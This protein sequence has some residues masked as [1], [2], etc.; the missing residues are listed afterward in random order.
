MD[1]LMPYE[2]FL[3]FR[4]LRSRNKRRLAR[5]TSIAAILG[6]CMGVAALIVAFAL[7]NG[8]RDEMREKIL[9]GTAHLSVVRADGRPIE[10]YAELENR[11]RQVEGVV[12]AS[13]TTY[14]GALARGSKGSGYAVIRGIENDAGQSVQLRQWLSEGSFGPL[15]EPSTSAVVGAELAARIGVSVGDTFFVLP[16][17]R[18]TSTQFE[19]LRVAGIFRSGLF[20]YDSTW[21]YVALDSASA[22]AGDNHAASVMSVQVSDADNVKQVAAAVAK[23][24]GNGYTTIDWQQANQP[25]FAALALERRM[26]LFIIGLIIA[27][28]T[29][30]ITTM[31]ILVVVERRRDI[32]ILSALGATRTGVMLLFIIEG[33]VVGGMGAGAGVLL[34]LAACFIGNHYKLV[35][36]PADVY[37]ISNVPLIARPGEMFLA[38]LIAFALSVLA[39][40]Y[41]ARAASRMRPVEALRDS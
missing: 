31:L 21:I 33:A 6:I 34:G 41:P 15:F 11:L 40:I 10:N 14:D 26:G 4:Y 19:Q 12:T 1:D 36:L 16:A 2:V 30:N 27:I 13:A 28:A 39:T 20:E 23:T 25:L 3:A 9:Q 35:S 7:S 37:S 8:F 38:A 29:L 24:L 32:A 22:L 5:A 17:N 18:S